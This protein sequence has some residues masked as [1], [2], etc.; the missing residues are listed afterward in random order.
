MDLRII[1]WDI[2]GTL[3]RSARSESF[4]E[5]MAPML[6]SV[7]G[8]S[9]RLEELVVS[10]MTDLQI[11]GEALRDEGFTH[12]QIRERVV[13]LRSSHMLEMERV[14]RQEDLFYL[15]PG[16]REA[17]E[18]VDQH[19]RY[20][21]ALLTGNIEPAARLKMQLVGLDEFFHLPGAFGDE[22][23]DRRDLP[24]F[25]ATRINEKLGM[26]L[27]PKHFIIIGD[28]PN[29]IVCARHFGARAVSV[30][31][32]R[33]FSLE[34]LFVSSSLMAFSLISLILKP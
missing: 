2:D 8:T 34:E 29:D 22:S 11:A 26:Q 17:L 14:V 18:A 31:T 32:G 6:K 27:K 23:H 25:A 1:L 5:Y 19:P 9:G 30:A 3:I 10:G 21:S 24:H 7:F 33:N 16:A 13:E 12:Q 20:Q 15:L 28:T 4:K